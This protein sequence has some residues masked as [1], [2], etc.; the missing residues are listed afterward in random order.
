MNLL[1]VDDEAAVR[2][3]FTELC[4]RGED[5]RLIGEILAAL[6]PRRRGCV[7]DGTR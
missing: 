5:L 4:E 6:P 3:G 2:A 1:I 7:H